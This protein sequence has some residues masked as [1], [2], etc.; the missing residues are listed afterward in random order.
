MDH[1]RTDPRPADRDVFAGPP[2]TRVETSRVPQVVLFMIFLVSFLSKLA[3][4]STIPTVSVIPDEIGYTNIARYVATLSVSGFSR[5]VPHGPPLYPIVLS[6]AFLLPDMGASYFIMKV[7]NSLLLST[8]VFPIWAFFRNYLDW[9]ESAA[10]TLVSLFM[11]WTLIYPSYIMAENLLIPLFLSSIILEVQALVRPSKKNDLLLG[12]LLSLSYLT[13]Y[14]GILLLVPFTL[15][16]AVQALEK[17]K[18]ESNCASDSRAHFLHSV[19]EFFSLIKGRWLVF[20]TF[21]L[22][23]APF[24]I[25]GAMSMSIVP[26]LVLV[27]APPWRW[28][29]PLVLGWT[30]MQFNYGVLAVAVLPFVAGFALLVNSWRTRHAVRDQ[31]FLY[32]FAIISLFFVLVFVTSVLNVYIFDPSEEGVGGR[33]LDPALPGLVCVGI[34]GLKRAKV[35]PSRY[36]F[37]ALLVLCL[38][39]IS[40]LSSSRMWQLITPSH[41]IGIIY[42]PQVYVLLLHTFPLYHIDING[43]LVPA[44]LALLCLVMASLVSVRRL[45]RSESLRFAAILLMIFSLLSS[46]ASY[47]LVHW[48]ANYSDHELHISQWITRQDITN[49]TLLVDQASEI[50]VSRV[51]FG[52][53]FWV[54][55]KNNIRV[56]PSDLS[57]APKGAYILSSAKLDLPLALSYATNGTIYYVYH[58]NSTVATQLS[59]RTL[60]PRILPDR[61]ATAICS[62]SSIA[63]RILG[64]PTANTLDDQLIQPIPGD[65]PSTDPESCG[66]F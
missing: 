12:C 25:W 58:A 33:Y 13:K 5:P 4:A 8:I 11:P 48:S 46:Y 38:T 41:S 20:V 56:M 47:D 63:N 23:A 51:A 39:S 44:W 22:V 54:G 21:I 60:S 17:Q 36:G 55:E 1:L 24:T 26:R 62:L 34:I 53:Q 2:V 28:S 31:A 7:I 57:E 37:L 16:I 10:F 52:V 64:H 3:L 66:V 32:A 40:I 9:K 61:D 27:V 6:P 19:R 50:P 29:L 35:S 30:V 49:A 14:T 15:L 59:T 43:L 65:A 42:V 18:R 45:R